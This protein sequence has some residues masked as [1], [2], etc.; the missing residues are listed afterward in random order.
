MKKTF[1]KLVSAALCF[2]LA[3]SSLFAVQAADDPCLTDFPVIYIKGQ[4]DPIVRVNESGET[5]QLYPVELPV[6]DF[7]KIAEDNI[8]ILAKAVITQKWTEFGN[9]VRDTLLPI[10]GR[11][12]LDKNGKPADGSYCEYAYCNDTINS[13]TVN[14]KYRVNQF[15]FRYDW[16]LDPY[17][18]ADELHEYIEKVLAKTKCDHV[19]IVSR[20]LGSCIAAAYMEKY[21]GE[22]VTDLVLY[23]SA[24]NGISKCSKVFAGDL[25]LNSGAVERYV[26][27]STVTSDP[28]VNE[29][30]QA[31]VTVF[32]SVYGMEPACF[33]F[34]IVWQ[35]I[36]KDILPQVLSETIGT[37]P[38]FWSM[39]NDADYERAKDNV[40]HNRDLNEW[41]GFIKKI[42]R[43]HYNVQVKAPENFKK[44]AGRDISI[45][46][47]TKYGFQTMPIFS[48]PDLLSD[49]DCSVEA[50]SMGAATS[51]VDST[52]SRKY[53]A[54]ADA[55][56]ISPDRQ[57]DAS[58]CLFPERTWFIKNLIHNDFPA[59]VDPLI[60]RMVNSHTM[61]VDSDEAYPQYMVYSEGELVPMTT[62][63]CEVKSYR[64]SFFEAVQII[65]RNLFRLIISRLFR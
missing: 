30:F 9:L 39:V 55:R 40:F 64:H 47:I 57:I 42:D 45:F 31:F 58:T 19:G 59:A 54:S 33:S 65:I 44:Y 62:E 21:D 14:G 16:R 35:N 8:D 1:V 10:Y 52:L 34:N 43:Y 51:G 27:D 46:N 60:C 56:F 3:F 22:Y 11:L 53:L 25:Y 2:L 15:S 18:I 17:E 12:A 61:T 32:R 6:G 29:L 7:I 38:G 63:N 13:T 48:P 49:R 24:L 37:F 36:Y 28:V 50:A 26:Y 20:C 5:E 23:A 4:G 41:A